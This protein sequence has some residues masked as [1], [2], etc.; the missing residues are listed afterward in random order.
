MTD[1]AM[2]EAMQAVATNY[3]S[4]MKKLRTGM[5]EGPFGPPVVLTAS[6]ATTLYRMMTEQAGMRDVVPVSPKGRR[7]G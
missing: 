6:E 2:Q 1:A 5:N 7:F 3:N 4:A